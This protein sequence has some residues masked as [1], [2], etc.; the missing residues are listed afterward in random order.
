MTSDDSNGR[1]FS[2]AAEPRTVMILEKKHLPDHL[3]GLP[4]CESPTH[5]SGILRELEDAG[6]VWV[7]RSTHWYITNKFVIETWYHLIMYM[8]NMRLHVSTYM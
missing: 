3:S 4:C 2:F 5:L 6:E 1:W 8:Y 7:I